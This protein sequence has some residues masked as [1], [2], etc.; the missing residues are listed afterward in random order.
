MHEMDVRIAAFDSD[1][2]D[3]AY[4]FDGPDD[5]EFDMRDS[6]VE[7]GYVEADSFYPFHLAD[8]VTYI[9]NVDFSYGA[10]TASVDGYGEGVWTMRNV[11]M[12]FTRVE[13][14]WCGDFY[15]LDVYYARAQFDQLSLYAGDLESDSCDG[16]LIYTYDTQLTLTNSR[17]EFDEADMVNNIYGIY[18]G[19][20]GTYVYDN[21]DIVLGF[22]NDRDNYGIYQ[23]Y[24]SSE[25]T[26]NYVYA[27]ETWTDAD[28][29]DDIWGIYVEYGLARL[30][31][32]VVEM[33]AS[34]DEATGLHL[35]GDGLVA[36]ASNNYFAATTLSVADNVYGVYIELDGYYVLQNN[37]INAGAADDSFVNY[38]VYID[39]LAA[40]TVLQGNIFTSEANQI[41][42][43]VYDHSAG[44][45]TTMTEV[46]DC[47]AWAACVAS[48]DNKKVSD[49][50]N[51]FVNR[52]NGNFKQKA[53]SP[54]IDAG[55][56]VNQYDPYGLA[57]VDMNGTPR[58]SAGG[59]DIGPDELPQ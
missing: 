16:Y 23:A 46:N 53:T 6:V 47:S 24:G 2:I 18:G 50:D 20:G 17:L 8:G 45:L 21:N 36:Y 30:A 3:N 38:G 49:P 42:V 1:R 57:A 28:E 32:N 9:E 35:Y 51:I 15:L 7:I 29:G 12:N 10:V 11:D 52:A 58:P 55:V 34:G 56:D 13:D 19:D 44:D 4:V 41:D 39:D 31:N 33:G 27:G 40:R 37:V 25:I 59:W 43:L 48:R 26:N 54:A 5:G 14:T 22:N